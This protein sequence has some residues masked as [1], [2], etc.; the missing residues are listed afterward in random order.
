M[1]FLRA[2]RDKDDALII[3]DPQPVESVAD[4]WASAAEAATIGIFLLLLAGALDLAPTPL[5]KPG[6]PERRLGTLD[7]SCTNG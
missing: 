7:L 4:A 1:E 2:R 5:R 6:P 3:S